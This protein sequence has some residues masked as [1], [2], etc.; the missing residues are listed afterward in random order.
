MV[1]TLVGGV[2]RQGGREWSPQNAFL[3]WLSLAMDLNSPE[4]K[5][6]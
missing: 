4:M 2:L 3:P 5:N 1:K 6:L